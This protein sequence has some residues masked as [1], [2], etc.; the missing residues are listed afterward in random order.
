MA[1]VD[2]ND[3]KDDISDSPDEANSCDSDQNNL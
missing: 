1:G 3:I 2:Y